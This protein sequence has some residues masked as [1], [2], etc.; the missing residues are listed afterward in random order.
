MSSMAC[1]E[2]DRLATEF[3]HAPLNS[4]LDELAETESRWKIV[5]TRPTLSFMRQYRWHNRR[6]RVESQ[7]PH[8][9][10]RQLDSHGPR[11]A[12][13]WSHPMWPR[14]GYMSAWNPFKKL[15]PVDRQIPTRCGLWLVSRRVLRQ[16]RE[17]RQLDNSSTVT[18]VAAWRT[19]GRRAWP[20]RVVS[21]FC[22]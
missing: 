17:I 5:M 11:R 20:S 2:H 18:G 9:R 4:A 10:L 21:T 15:W 6:L 14:P 1:E 7:R 19:K 16:D 8:A 3:T 22:R 12:L 13:R